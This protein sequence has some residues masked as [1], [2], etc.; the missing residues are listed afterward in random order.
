VE[1]SVVL[2]NTYL[3]AFLLGRYGMVRSGFPLALK[4]VLLFDTATLLLLKAFDPLFSK[5]FYLLSGYFKLIFR[6]LTRGFR[7]TIYQYG[8]GYY[9]YPFQHQLVFKVGRSSRSYISLTNSVYFVQG[10]KRH[11]RVIGFCAYKN[12]FLK[13]MRFIQ[14]R[15]PVSTYDPRKGVYVRGKVYFIKKSGKLARKGGKKK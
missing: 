12:D 2:K 3:K 14:V 7:R 4:G 11:R 5:F 10:I 8:L 13:L 1:K 9:Y 6:S 15:K